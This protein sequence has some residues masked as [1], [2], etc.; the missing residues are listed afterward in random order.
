MSILL[1]NTAV[2]IGLLEVNGT[3]PFFIRILEQPQNQI[4]FLPHCN[5]SLNVFSSSSMFR[6]SFQCCS[7]DNLLQTLAYIDRGLFKSL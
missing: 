2:L 6:N 1:S 5:N 4:Q 7:R 3:S